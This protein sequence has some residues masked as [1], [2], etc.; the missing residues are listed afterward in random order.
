MRTSKNFDGISPTNK[1]I[2][3]LLDELLAQI[4]KQT[5]HQGVEIVAAWEQVLGAQ[6]AS[7]TRAVGV[8]DGVLT[9][10]V[11]SSTLYSLLHQHEKPRLL[12]RLQELFPRA[13]LKDI[14]F[15]VGRFT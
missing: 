1:P 3:P 14:V 11:K 15:R 5:V 10:K 4:Q 7:L 13:G 6:F 8:Q 2:G 9:V 12:A